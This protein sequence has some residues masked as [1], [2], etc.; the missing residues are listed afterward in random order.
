[1]NSDAL[2]KMLIQSLQNSNVLAKIEEAH[3]RSNTYTS[4]I[5]FIQKAMEKESFF[6]RYPKPILNKLIE[7]YS[8]PEAIVSSIKEKFKIYPSIKQEADHKQKYFSN[9]PEGYFRVWINQYKHTDSEKAEFIQEVSDSFTTIKHTSTLIYVSNKEIIPFLEKYKDSDFFF[10]KEIYRETNIEWT[11]ELINRFKDLWDWNELHR[12]PVI[13]WNFDLIK[14]N[15]ENLN[16]SFISSYS[17]LEWDIELIE[18]YKVDLIFSL[19]SGSSHERNAKAGTNKKGKTYSIEKIG[20]S[21]DHYFSDLEGTLSLSKSIKW[22]KGIIKEFQ[23]FWNWEELCRNESIPWSESWIDH[24]V[25]CVDFNSLSSNGSVKWT[26]SLVAKYFDKWCWWSLSGNPSLPW[27]FEFIKK[28][29]S[30]WQWTPIYED[31]D[32]DHITNES[33]SPSISTNK[34]I[35]WDNSL[36]EEWYEKINIWRIAI[37]GQISDEVLLKFHG[38]FDRKVQIGWEFHRSSDWKETEKLYRTGWENLALNP[39]FEI[40]W[41]NIDFLYRKKV[42]KTRSVG[43]L[44]KDGEYQ[45]KEYRVLELLKK[46]KIEGIS[47]QDII[48]N[49]IGWTQN[50]LNEEFINES[51]WNDLLRPVFDRNF[52]LCYLQDLMPNIDIEVLKR[53][54]FL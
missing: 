31:K 33:F 19:S 42:I 28:Y 22:T 13:N 49:E 10:W 9:S 8:F 2:F 35:F 27:S 41:K 40:N 43:N 7:M 17:N 3:D 54:S 24:F 4:I 37:I 26:D 48:D 15:S 53:N 30:K 39:Y 23:D 25:D 14:D 21:D 18:T 36:V 32:A 52:S 46:C 45:T 34:G 16:W 44:A 38:D 20:V 11:N 51:I 50:I 1:M 5:T 12:N 29:E 47:L 6:K